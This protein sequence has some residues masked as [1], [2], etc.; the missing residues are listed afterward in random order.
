MRF[1]VNPFSK[2]VL[3]G[4]I[5]YMLGLLIYV[6][7]KC[8]KG[9]A[10]FTLFTI[11][12]F[13][14]WFILALTAFD[15]KFELVLVQGHEKALHIAYYRYGTLKKMETD[16]E[17]FTFIVRKSTSKYGNDSPYM[18]FRNNG[19]F[20]GNFYFKSKKEALE[21]SRQLNAAKPL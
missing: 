12:F 11:S 2:R 21:L 5:P 3:T 19:K 20:I 8:I 10:D 6:L 4:S 14:F 7:Y 15:N 9:D 16:W 13:V 17:S 1:E 18:E